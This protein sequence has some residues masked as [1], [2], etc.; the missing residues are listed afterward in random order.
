MSR[1]IMPAMQVG[2]EFLLSKP[3]K[4]DMK[5]EVLAPEA[6][7]PPQSL[8]V[9]VDS[10]QLQVAAPEVASETPDSSA[11]SEHGLRPTHNI[12]KAVHGIIDAVRHYKL[13]TIALIILL[14]GAA[15]I[16]LAGRYWTAKHITNHVTSTA[17]IKTGTRPISGLNLTV[18][19]ADFQTKLQ[20]ITNQPATIAVGTY[21]MPVGSDTIR[22]WLQIT[23]NKSKSEYYIHLN[24]AAIA[25]SLT[26]LANKY[27][28]SPANQVTVNED[29]VDRV[30]VG[31]RNG[32][33]LS[34]PNSLTVQAQQVAKTVMDGKGLQ[35]NTP[36]ATVP[37]QAVGPG[38]FDKVLVASI[39]AKKMWAYQNGNQV[40]SWLISAGK[41]STPTP[42]GQFKVYAKYAVQDMKGTNPD[43]SPYFQPH[44]RWISYF[45]QGSAVH[46]VYWHPL[47]WFGVNNSSHGCIG[48]PEDEA[49]WVY[50]WAPIGTTVIVT[51]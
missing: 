6:S 34:D 15:S 9:A 36:L 44:V 8:A 19:Q 28:K 47:S 51:T 10:T 2:N 46:G 32:T 38:A 25:G 14:F 21:T 22:S 4:L 11:A 43:G 17:A 24:K 29:G 33:A 40:N 48:L 35:F 49:Q 13:A 5:V 45:Y 3:K 42:V 37:F 23:S 41:P 7:L 31:G 30:V 12:H 27:V 50:N 20:T 26:Q 1:A 16:T 18:P 39:S